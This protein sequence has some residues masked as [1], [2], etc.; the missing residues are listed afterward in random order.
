MTI[1]TVH[2]ASSLI[3]KASKS[4]MQKRAVK[5]LFGTT[6]DRNELRQQLERMDRENNQ[7]LQNYKVYGV[8]GN[9][10]NYRP[11]K[12]GYAKGVETEDESVEKTQRTV[13]SREAFSSDEPS[14]SSSSS[15]K[16]KQTSTSSSK[17]SDV[18]LMQQKVPLPKGQK[19][20]KGKQILK[21]CTTH[22][23]LTSFF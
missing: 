17:K 3:I 8:I 13:S 5:N 6:V 1:G 12:K 20:L 23:G 9:S 15:L 18:K 2:Q 11:R 22:T 21:H 7:K 4:D 14:S 19:T 16:L 10:V